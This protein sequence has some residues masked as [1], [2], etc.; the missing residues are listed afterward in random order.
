[1]REFGQQAFIWKTIKTVRL[2]LPSRIPQRI[3]KGCVSNSFL[4]LPSDWFFNGKFV[5]KLSWNSKQ[6]KKIYIVFQVSLRA[7]IRLA[8]YLK[9]FDAK[10]SIGEDIK[11]SKPVEETLNQHLIHKL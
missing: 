4:C 3:I 9:S 11:C 2:E 10:K 6:L 1:M 5:N 7:A 8:F